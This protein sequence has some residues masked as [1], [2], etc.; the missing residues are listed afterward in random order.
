MALRKEQNQAQMVELV[1][2]GLQD[3]KALTCMAGPE[4][5][6]AFPLAHNNDVISPP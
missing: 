6:R 4:L 3:V 1:Y 2:K 5:E